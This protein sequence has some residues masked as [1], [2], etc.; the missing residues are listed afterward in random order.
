MNSGSQVSNRLND[1]YK[2]YFQDK[3]FKLG[4]SFDPVKNN[5]SNEDF[6]LSQ[7]LLGY[8]SQQ[9][10]LTNNYNQTN[11]TIEQDRSKALQEN[12]IAKEK[13]KKYL[14]QYL[15]ANGMGNQG[16]AVSAILEANN[17]FANNRSFINQNAQARKDEILKNYTTNMGNLDTAYLNDAEDIRS[18]YQAKFEEDSAGH[19]YNLEQEIASA[20][21]KLIYKDGAIKKEDLAKIE[22]IYNNSKHL[23][24]EV[25]QN[26][27]RNKINEIKTIDSDERVVK[28]LETFNYKGSTYKI[29]SKLDSNSN[30]LTRNSD[31]KNKLKKLGFTN[32]YDSKIPNGTTLEVKGDNRGADDFNFHDDILGFLFTPGGAGAYHSWANNT[33]HYMT[34]YNGN[35]YRSEKK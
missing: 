5:M 22:E 25:D 14:S 27:I 19:M 21:N 15:N 1:L 24:T 8:Y 11:Q 34:Y 18:K 29:V 35:W 33:T 6:D 13:S 7:K 9:N 17:N 3:E 32:A 4:D 23:L 16:T 31:F 12:A 20:V 26:T 10:N 30:L 2:K 28:G